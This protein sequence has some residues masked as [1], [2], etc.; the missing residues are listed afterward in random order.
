[1]IQIT[2]WCCSI[3]ESVCETVLFHP[4][5]QGLISSSKWACIAGRSTSIP[6]VVR[7]ES[8]SVHTSC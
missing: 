3:K 8:A 2:T 6:S 1:M 4:N 7:T 5:G